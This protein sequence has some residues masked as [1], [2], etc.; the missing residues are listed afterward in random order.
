MTKTIG[1]GFM[2]S[3]SWYW[4]EIKKKVSA[5]T[6]FYF[7]LTPLNFQPTDQMN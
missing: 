5:I 4:N 2:N 3:L 7:L 1:L 6:H